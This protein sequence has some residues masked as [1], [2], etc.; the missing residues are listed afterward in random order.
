MAEPDRAEQEAASRSE[1]GAERGAG[2][3]EIR[4]ALASA[5]RIVISSHRNADGDAA[6]SEAALAHWVRARGIRPTLVNATPFPDRFRFLLDD[7]EEFTAGEDGA[8]DAVAQ[9]DLAVVVDTSER[10]RLGEVWDLLEAREDLP[11][12][13][14]DHHPPSPESIGD[15]AWRDSSACATAELLFRLMT[16][17]EE[18]EDG[19]AGGL[20]PEVARALYVGIVTD[21]GSFRF[22]NATPAA[23]RITARLIEAGVDPQAM[24]RHLYARLTLPRARLLQRALGKLR[25]DPELPLAWL[26]LSQNDLRESGATGEEREGLVEY[27]RRLE[28]VEVAL[29]FREMTDGRTKVS[30]RSNGPV[31]VSALAARYGGGGH[32]KASGAVVELPMEAA[33]GAVL[34]DVREGLRARRESP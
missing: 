5:S 33:V 15:P 28:G 34:S 24:Y 7:L 3:P 20:A 11:V 8:R 1:A 30:F 26:T 25:R 18:T 9:A 10:H 29:L 12:A 13:V 4:R 14:V 32:V 27:A 31:D 16:E 22:S 6:G 19:E 23:H 21:T 2:A 17:T